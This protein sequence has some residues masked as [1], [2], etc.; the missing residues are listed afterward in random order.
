MF[1]V[2]DQV[3]AMFGFQAI[4][5]SDNGLPFQNGQWKKY[6][7]TSGIKHHKIKAKW[8]QTNAQ[9][10]SFNKPLMKAIRAAQLQKRNW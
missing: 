6:M 10:E 8:P 3:F 7:K 1:P 9:A 4:V 5:K 2:I